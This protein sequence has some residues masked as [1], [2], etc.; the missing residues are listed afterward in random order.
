M[1]RPTLYIANKNYSS[2]SF[3]PWMA[4]TGLGIDFEEVLI[5][6][7]DAAGNPNIKAVSPTGRVP[8]LQHGTLKIWESLAIIE[9]AAELYPDAGLLLLIVPS[10]R[11]PARFRW[12]CCRAS[13][14]C[15]APAR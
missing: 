3:R 9:Y 10:G 15:A 6:F 14:L 7:D 8:L 2:W 1:D 4:L 13:G 5:P 12:K 11:L